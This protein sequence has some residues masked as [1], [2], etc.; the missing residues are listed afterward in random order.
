MALA[1]WSSGQPCVAM[2]EP[3]LFQ[4]LDSLEFGLKN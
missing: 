3:V 1:Q 2:S 4:G